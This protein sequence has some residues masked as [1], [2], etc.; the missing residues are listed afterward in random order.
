MKFWELLEKELTAQF[1]KPPAK[2]PKNQVS[3]GTSNC[4][5]AIKKFK[6]GEEDEVTKKTIVREVKIL[7]QLKHPNI[8]HLREGFKVY[9]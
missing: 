5:V 7:R 4:L 2:K 8:V 9:I 1:I 6:D 3:L